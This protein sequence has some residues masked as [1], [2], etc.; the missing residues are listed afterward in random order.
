MDLYAGSGHTESFPRQALQAW[1][2]LPQLAAVITAMTALAVLAGWIFSIPFLKSVLS[3]AIAMQPDTAGG[4]LLSACGLF[5]LGS[6]PSP[7]LRRLAQAFAV[8][9]VLLGLAVAGKYLF[10]WSLEYI[11][12]HNGTVDSAGELSDRM[13]PL[14]VLCFIL[15]GSALFVLHR[16]ALHLMA[17][18]LSITVLAIGIVSVLGYLWDVDEFV[19]GQWL[20]PIALN[21]AFA[22]ALLGAGIAGV[23]M[24]SE[25]LQQG[26]SSIELKML[27]GFLTAVLLLVM[28]GGVTYRVGVEYEKSEM[29]IELSQDR[30]NALEQLYVALL[31]AEALQRGYLL[32]GASSERQDYLQFVAGVDETKRKLIQLIGSD[33]AQMQ[34]LAELSQLI[35]RRLDRLARHREI[36][37]R[38][39]FAAAVAA[40][41]QNDGAQTMA[42][43]RERIGKMN[44]LEAEYL[45]KNRESL[46]HHRELTLIA[47]VSTIGVAIGILLPLFRGA[48][49]EIYARARMEKLLGQE[50]DNAE[51]ASHAKDSFLATMSHEIRTPLTGMLGM[52]EML[53]LTRL[54][55]DQSETLEAAWDSGRSL[56]RIVNDILDWSRIEE[57]KLTLAPHSVSIPRLLQDVVGTYAHVA[58]TKGLLLWQYADPRLSA[59]HIVDPLRLSQVLNNFVSNAVKFTERGEVELRAEFLERHASGELIRFSVRDTG[60]GI[61]E[62]ARQHLF[63]RYRQESADTT[64]MYGGTGLGLAICRRL[65]DMMDGQIALESVVGKGSTFSF[66][67][68][69]PISDAPGETISRRHLEVESQVVKPLVEQGGDA[70]S[71]LVVDDHPINRNL[72]A[73]QVRLLGLRAET[74]ENGRQALEM[75]RAG[76]FALVITDC[77]MPEMDGYDLS[78]EIRRAEIMRNAVRTP[79]IAWTANAM[80]EEME[81]CRAAGMDELLVKPTDMAQLRKILKK[82]LPEETVNGDAVASGHA[83]KREAGPIDHAELERTVP[84]RSEHW[85]VLHDFQAHIHSDY[86]RLLEMQANRSEVE[87]IAHRMKGSCRMVGARKLADICANIERLA[88]DADMDGARA[89]EVQLEEAIGQLDAYLSELNGRGAKG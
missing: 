81:R 5:I 56:L 86:S 60:I 34:N 29:L 4:L 18:L 67:V 48:R 23:T 61:A 27:V 17:R 74:A 24:R 46:R 76:H 10:G 44:A 89:A 15:V 45:D 58:S 37:E 42:A 80:A 70:P 33:V 16:Q 63:Q 69:L 7:P 38:Q 35:E 53:S 31:N 30:R 14:S 39:G 32:T 6:R 20:P 71:V 50:R 85:Q 3:G 12:L 88:H 41:K 13:S 2:T 62:D 22:F 57:G 75:W 54:D 59:S 36:F 51:Q 52:L 79:V 8:L 78:R 64:R 26:T 11:E 25:E 66:T 87:H 19:S 68:M 82:W 40:V 1:G 83:G 21:T 77:H 28:M 55:H 72:L 49:R 43:I 9:V 47:L 84:D 65:A 73:R